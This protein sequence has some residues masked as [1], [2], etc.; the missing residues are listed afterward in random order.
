[1]MTSG[2]YFS[3]SA[4]ETSSAVGT[5]ARLPYCV[6][7]AGRGPWVWSWAFVIQVD[8]RG[9]Q[10][11]PLWQGV[12]GSIRVWGSCNLLYI[13]LTLKVAPKLS[14]NVPCHWV[15]GC[16]VRLRFMALYPSL[17]SF[18]RPFKDE[19]IVHPADQ[20]LSCSG[21]YGWWLVSQYL[22]DS[23]GDIPCC[24]FHP[25]VEKVGSAFRWPTSCN[26]MVISTQIHLQSKALLTLTR[27]QRNLLIFLASTISGL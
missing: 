17:L 7:Y 12:L 1:M 13:G 20:W 24:P 27:E 8:R 25:G 10:T 26:K 11:V 16:R 19:T 15:K 22:L 14:K 4:P 5:T 23:A 3:L 21:A 18:D 6:R 9:L 2:N